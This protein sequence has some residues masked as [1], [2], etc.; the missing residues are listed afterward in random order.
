MYQ[1]KNINEK[2]LKQKNQCTVL[3][4]SM[5]AVIINKNNHTIH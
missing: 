3:T 2:K 4:E 1:T 5:K